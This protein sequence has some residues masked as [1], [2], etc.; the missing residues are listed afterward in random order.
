MQLVAK[1]QLQKK[2]IK[3]Y[4][5]SRVSMGGG[6]VGTSLGSLEPHNYAHYNYASAHSAMHKPK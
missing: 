4:A 1:K 2:D 3:P 6:P 5:K